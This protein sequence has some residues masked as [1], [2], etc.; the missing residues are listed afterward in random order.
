MDWY[1]MVWLITWYGLVRKSSTTEQWAL[2]DVAITQLGQT[3]GDHHGFIIIMI[4]ICGVNDIY[5][6]VSWCK[7]GDIRITNAL[8]EKILIANLFGGEMAMHGAACSHFLPQL[9]SFKSLHF[10]QIFQQQLRPR[11]ASRSWGD[12]GRSLTGGRRNSVIVSLLV[13]AQTPS[14]WKTQFFNALL[15]EAWSI[16]KIIIIPSF[17]QYEG[18]IFATACSPSHR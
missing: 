5:H 4:I 10:F 18:S 6:T 11:E 1:G 12:A 17:L 15:I 3:N 14:N 7:Y 8:Q 16:V 2:L 9:H 13:C